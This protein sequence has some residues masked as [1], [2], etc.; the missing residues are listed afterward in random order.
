VGE[1][2]FERARYPI[3]A[4]QRPNNLFSQ[5]FFLGALSHGAGCVTAGAGAGAGAFKDSSTILTGAGFFFGAAVFFAAGF[6][7]GA[8]AFFF[9]VAISV[10]SLPSVLMYYLLTRPNARSFGLR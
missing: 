7:A 2:A 6:F 1:R 9:V 5:L 8:D 10:I 4:F 3:Y